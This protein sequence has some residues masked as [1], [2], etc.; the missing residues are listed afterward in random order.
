M[1]QCCSQFIPKLI[2][3]LL[4]LVEQLLIFR[5]QRVG[6]VAFLFRGVRVLDIQVVNRPVVTVAGGLF[7]PGLLAQRV[8]LLA[9]SLNLRLDLL[10]NARLFLALDGVVA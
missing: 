7:V 5:Q 3:G 2:L 4:D 6:I 1:R 9:Q 10:A 8:N